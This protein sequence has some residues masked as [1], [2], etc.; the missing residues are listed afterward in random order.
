MAP[1][2]RRRRIGGKL[3]VPLGIGVRAA[4]DPVVLERVSDA[5]T[6]LRK[7]KSDHKASMKARISEAT[8]E[9]TP[10]VIH[11]ISEPRDDLQ[12]AGGVDA[13]ILVPASDDAPLSVRAILAE[14]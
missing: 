2:D 1:L 4:G 9:G 14:N 13:L 3:V 7:T 12:A 11:A 5:L 10:S 8:I 6:G